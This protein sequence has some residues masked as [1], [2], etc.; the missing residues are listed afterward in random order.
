MNILIK[1]IAANLA[2]LGLTIGL[3]MAATQAHA[4]TAPARFE[5]PGFDAT[6]VGARNIRNYGRDGCKRGNVICF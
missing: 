6:T 4:G 3:A 1:I 5:A 2:A